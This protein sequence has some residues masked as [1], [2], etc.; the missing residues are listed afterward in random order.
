MPEKVP[1]HSKDAEQSVLGAIMVSREALADVL[2]IL[3]PDD[4]YDSA[5]REI[6]GAITEL[7]EE[8]KNVD[9]ITVSDALK[10]KGSLEAAGGRAYIADLPNL[11]P[12]AVNAKGYAEIVKEKA[13]LRALIAAA[14]EMKASGYDEGVSPKII[15]DRAEQ[16]I[17]EIGENR[18]QN[19][20]KPLKKVLEKNLDL[21]DRASKNKGALLGL[22]TGFTELDK[23]TSGLQKS[24]LII[25]AAR[26]AM[27]KSAFAL[28][29]ALN[30][31][32]KTGASVIVFNLEMSDTQMGMRLLSID[33]KVEIQKIKNGTV[34]GEE[35][36]K[37]SVATDKLSACKIVIDDTPGIS[38]TEMKNKCRR[39]KKAQGL[40]LIIIDYL[41][42][43]DLGERRIESRQLEVG[44]ITRSFKLLAKELDCPVLLLS[45]LSREPEKRGD[46][47]P[48]PADL[49]DSGS[50]EQD[51]DMIMFLY[52]DEVYTHDECE[53]PGIC[54]VILS[55]NRNGPTGVA[56]LTFVERYTKFSDIP[57]TNEQE[58]K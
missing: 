33:S 9:I 35:W 42:L 21:I 26:P 48:I 52:R 25:L 4:F 11:A 36:K 47:R 56:K 39:L 1:P 45:Q 3:D 5:H 34:S 12:V 22:T 19:E 2:Q 17:F 20:Y 16:K 53:E 54:E 38:I 30:A 55:K 43:M 15:I 57:F 40:D 49:R 8:D 44:K 29:L 46:H 32:T 31:S 41:Q 50:I 37:I 28:N 58:K 24:D 51:A 18:Q 10:R 27:G 13:G 14:D 6:Y 23:L 7:S